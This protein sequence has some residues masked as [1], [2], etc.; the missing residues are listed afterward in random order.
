MSE[1]AELLSLAQR[2]LLGGVALAC[3]D[4]RQHY[5][6]LPGETL[7]QA[8]PARRA[9]FSAGR[10]AA[11]QALQH[12]GLP[13]RAI[14]A[15]ADRSPLWPLGISG[16]IT[17]SRS[18]C[19][20]AVRHGAG[21]GLDLEEAEGLER[22]LWPSILSESEQL[23]AYDQPDPGLA[24]KL[25]FCAKEAAYK[26]QYSHSGQLF[27]FESLKITVTGEAFT[28]SFNE[29]IAPFRKGD[30]IKGRWGLASGHILTAAAL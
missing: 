28:A 19:L 4:P 5:P 20:A 21:I 12:L 8:T 18:A 17:H 27:G 13:G 2:L 26:A 16:T 10:H 24:A 22:D 11:R 6:L 30:A 1:N 29:N 7:P 15:H 3:A 9:E 23:W 14:P 25:I